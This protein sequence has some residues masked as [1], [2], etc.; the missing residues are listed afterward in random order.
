MPEASA[1]PSA[2]A[3]LIVLSPANDAMVSTRTTVDHR[4][5]EVAECFAVF[6]EKKRISI[7][8]DGKIRIGNLRLTGGTSN[9]ALEIEG[10]VTIVGE[11]LLLLHY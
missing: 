11:E 1:S 2:I 4:W 9:L 7:K 8:F 3:T 5:P 6:R 10:L